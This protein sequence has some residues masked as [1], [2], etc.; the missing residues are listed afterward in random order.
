MSYNL[1]L[2]DIRN[3][4]DAA[5]YLP[6]LMTLYENNEWVIVKS[7]KKFVN[8]I[9]TKG[10]PR[11]VSV[12]HDLGDANAKSG[13]DAVKWLFEYI[14]TNEIKEKPKVVCHSMN[15]VGRQNI[16]NLVI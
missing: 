14:R 5:T 1:F 12:D 9:K 10:V 3:P 8:C 11:V 2:D 4:S 6:H 7:Y 13:Y 16:E 15:P